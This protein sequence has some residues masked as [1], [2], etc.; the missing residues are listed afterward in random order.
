MFKP[1]PQT[2]NGGNLYVSLKKDGDLVRGI[3][4]GEPKT[5]RIHWINGKGIDCLGEGCP[6]CAAGDKSKFRFTC[7]FIVEENGMYVAKLFESGKTV[8]DA[9]AEQGADYDMSKT[10]VKIT[11]K[12]TGMDTTYAVTIAPPDKQPTKEQLET[13][14]AVQLVTIGD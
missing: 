13:I 11:R 5:F 7:N 9:L 14:K 8:Y 2:G 4:A 12:G 6:H 1:L 3:F 10:L